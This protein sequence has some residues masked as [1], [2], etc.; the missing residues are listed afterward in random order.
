MAISSHRLLLFSEEQYMMK[1]GGYNVK[2]LAPFCNLVFQYG[3]SLKCQ[4][5]VSARTCFCF[6]THHCDRGYSRSG[7]YSN[8][9]IVAV[10]EHEEFAA[11]LH[12][13]NFCVAMLTK[14]MRP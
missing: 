10:S 1:I 11:I 2:I 12:V 14:I 6:L 9:V 7:L 5:A 4:L 8:S 13:M 3:V